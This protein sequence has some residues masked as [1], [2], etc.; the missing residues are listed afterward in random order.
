MT[1]L[2]PVRLL[3]ALLAL[4]ACT[5]YDFS[6][7]RLP[8]GSLDT[9]KLIA[10]LNASGK[11]SLTEGFW[12]PLIH[13]DLQTFEKNGRELPAGY[14]LTM[15]KS[16][17]PLFFGGSTDEKIFD[18]DGGSIE[19]SDHEWIGWGLLY[20]DR[21]SYVGTKHGTRHGKRER[22]LLFFGSDDT[23]YALDRK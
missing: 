20:H 1:T 17:G 4:T 16:Y 14:T 9:K 6:Q 5:T 22:F 21:D 23:V 2:R 19:A 3:L 10:D 18:Q 13:L 11:D 12:I 15:V 7:A 8:D